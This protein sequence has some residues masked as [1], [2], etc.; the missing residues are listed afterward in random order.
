VAVVCLHLKESSL[1]LC[2]KFELMWLEIYV[3]ALVLSIW[4][5][6]QTSVTE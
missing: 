5:S 4:D 2:K 1:N 6:L 3:T